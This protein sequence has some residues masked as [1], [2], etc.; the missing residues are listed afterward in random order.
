MYSYSIW[1][2]VQPIE[3]KRINAW[4]F[5]FAEE[6]QKRD[7]PNLRQQ[8][9][10]CVL[11]NY[12]EYGFFKSIAVSPGDERILTEVQRTMSPVAGFQDIVLYRVAR[13]PQ[14]SAH[15]DFGADAQDAGH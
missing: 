6:V 3:E 13:T 15:S 9:R 4:P 5:L 10:G 11:V 12:S 2:G 7:L 1:S 14:E 8:D